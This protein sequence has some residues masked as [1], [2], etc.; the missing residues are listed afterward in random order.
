[1]SFG[2]TPGRIVRLLLGEGAVLTTVGTLAGCFI[3]LQYAI[4]EGF[5]KGAMWNDIL[6]PEYWTDFFWAHFFIVSLIVYA[7][8][9]V[10]VSIGVYIPA[11]KI[12]RIPPTEALRDE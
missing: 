2:A 6:R 8:L 3:F 1:M 10:V 9:L 5:S 12:S 11:R 4:S 7:V